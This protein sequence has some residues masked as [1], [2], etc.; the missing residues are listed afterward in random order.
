MS[1]IS[2]VEPADGDL[3][4]PEAVRS[5]LRDKWQERS[6]EGQ[7]DVES[8]FGKRSVKDGTAS[9]FFFVLHGFTGFVIA[10]VMLLNGL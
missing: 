5:A 4:G 10:F 1:H 9:F 8:V 3:G 2:S 6:Q 7:E